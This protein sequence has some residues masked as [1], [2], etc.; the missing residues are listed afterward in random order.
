MG[1]AFQVMRDGAFSPFQVEGLNDP[2]PEGE[3]SLEG[4]V[5][6][7]Y[8]KKRQ[9]LL[10]HARRCLAGQRVAASRLEADDLLHEAVITT[11]ANHARKPIENLAGYMYAVI[12]R[13]VKDESRRV[14][15]AVPIDTTARAAAQTRFLHISDIEEVTPEGAVDRVDLEHAL[16][17]LPGQQKRM[18]TMAK[19]LGYS[20]AEISEITGL[21]VGTV[22]QHVRRGTRTLM[23][24]M[25]ATLSGGGFAL[26]M[27]ICSSGA[28]AWTKADPGSRSIVEKAS[29]ALGAPVPDVLAVIALIALLAVAAR[30]F[31]RLGGRSAE[32]TRARR[33]LPAVKDARKRLRKELGREPTVAE[34]AFDLGTSMEDVAEALAMRSRFSKYRWPIDADIE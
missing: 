12:S 33:T 23:Q 4:D 21:H 7:V 19:G 14:G 28:F 9:D 22:A 18:V 10:A 34:Y 11:M 2:L 26:M 3:G 15:F 8:R 1:A 16:R 13:R 30:L 29:E 27:F 6:A 20:H 31:Y 32:Q 25:S 24:L 5:A 17:Q